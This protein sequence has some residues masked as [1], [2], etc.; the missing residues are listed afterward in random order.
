MRQMHSPQRHGDTEKS[1]AEK[2]KALNV[3]ADISIASGS[4][5]L[6]VRKALIYSALSFPQGREPFQIKLLDSRLRVLLSGINTRTVFSREWRDYVIPAQAGIQSFK[7][8]RVVRQNILSATQSPYN[9]WIPACAGMTGVL[10]ERSSK[11]RRLASFAQL[12]ILLEWHILHGMDVES[13]L[14]IYPI[15]P[16][17]ATCSSDHKK[18]SQTVVRLRGISSHLAACC[19][20]GLASRFINDDL[21]SALLGRVSRRGG[22]YE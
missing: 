8:P 22:C 11:L 13:V 1:K 9:Y 10:N 6:W 14:S 20:S 21:I 5:K 12:R 17:T 18:L 4:R 2:S 16:C 7:H 19:L 3:G 15:R